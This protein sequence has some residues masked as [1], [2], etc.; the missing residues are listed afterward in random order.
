[1]EGRRNRLADYKTR[2]TGPSR[3]KRQ[4][5][6]QGRR[7]DARQAKLDAHRGLTEIDTNVMEPAPEPTHQQKL[8]E[9]LS[10][11]EVSEAH[12]GT[13]PPSSTARSSPTR[14]MKAARDRVHCEL[15][16]CFRRCG[17]SANRL[18]T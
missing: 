11:L 6:C 14:S 16:A 17:A 10:K 13:S 15:F 2:A 3:T 4:E 18:A 5:E 7:R 8:L 1:M 9:R 12:H